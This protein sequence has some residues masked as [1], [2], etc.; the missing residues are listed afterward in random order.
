MSINNLNILNQKSKK[1]LIFL[2]TL[3]LL[4]CSKKFDKIEWDYSTSEILIPKISTDINDS[5]EIFLFIDATLS[6]KGFVNV[7]NSIYSSFLEEFEANAQTGW[8][9]V[10]LNFFKFGTKIKKITREQFRQ[11]KNPSFY[12]EPG[13]YE[14][15]NIDSV[16]DFISNNYKPNHIY[17]LVSDFFQNEADINLLN[18]KIK[19]NCFTKN[20][21]IGILG[22]KSEFNGLVYDAKVP[23][24][25]YHS[26]TD[27]P[28]S[29]RNVI[30]LIF[31][32]ESN[33]INLIDKLN[34]PYINKNYF[35]LI[36][37]KIITNFT[38]N[39]SKP[40]E[41]IK[42]SLRA[43]K[44]ELNIYN[45]NLRD[46]TKSIN[47]NIELY[48]HT[49]PYIPQINYNKINIQC[50]YKYLTKQKSSKDSI[51]YNNVYLKQI[52]AEQNIIK[53]TIIIDIPEENAIY[54]FLIYFQPSPIDG[55]ILPNWVYEFSSDNPN[56]LKDQN[57]TLN[58]DK[59][60]I[61][62]VRSA[63][64]TFNFKIAKLYINIKKEV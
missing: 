26:K 41:K 15:T 6:M 14:K 50:F 43:S 54:S 16:I 40:K 56:P 1:Y 28:N 20:I 5:I 57:K 44:K 42:L 11:A 7:P 33:I 53:T 63:S 31:S 24:Y 21:S 64:V 17:V 58:F 45:F 36:P 47:L 61:N 32:N 46:K 10:K 3:I 35:I 13:I 19:Q 49:I 60:V 18:L 9:N 59:F 25:Y 29:Y 27:D 51:P 2:L 12:E 34:S 39:V 37:S 22:L 62:L 52:S 30:A 8:K 23:P 55:F 4:S 48:I 38:T